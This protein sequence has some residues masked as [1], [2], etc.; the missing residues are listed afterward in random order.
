MDP[1]KETKLLNGL[2]AAGALGAFG[3]AAYTVATGQIFS[4]GVDGLFFT[5]VCLLLAA[6]LAIVPLW[7]LYS[8]GGLR[9]LRGRGREAAA[10]GGVPNGLFLAIPG[11]DEG[12][13]HPPAST[14]Q[15]LIIW[16]WLL[17]LTFVEVLLGYL[18]IA[19]PL[20]MLIILMGLSIVKAAL[21]MG[22]FMHLKFE[23][24]SLIL[25]VVPAMVICISLLAI[26][27]PDSLRALNLKAFR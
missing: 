6:I 12:H 19:P 8:S 23:R 20:G 14:R 16:S 2:C 17:A 1:S 18:H 7:S 13:A 4:A 11:E 24:M 10:A 27:F 25:T 22:Y 5:L 3:A 15:T 9:F 26:F 21:I